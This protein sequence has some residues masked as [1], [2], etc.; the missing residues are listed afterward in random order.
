[1][2]VPAVRIVHLSPEA[3]AA[4][5]A[6]DLATAEALAPVPLTPWVVSDDAVVGTW[7]RRAVQVVEV[8][9][10]IDGD[11]VDIVVKDGERR[12]QVDEAESRAEIPSLED[13]AAQQF[14]SF[15]LRASRLDETLWEVAVLPL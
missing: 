6:R 5:A 7:Q 4:L 14:G 12:V 11:Q 9:E 2:S 8:P 13:F 10:D 1:M 15:V 3:L